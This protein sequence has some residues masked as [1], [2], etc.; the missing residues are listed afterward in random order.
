MSTATVSERHRNMA[1]AK[2]PH[3]LAFIGFGVVSQG[4]VQI[5]QAK[6]EHLASLGTS[7]QV[8]AISDLQKGAIYHPEGLALDQIMQSIERDGT[9]LSYPES[10]GLIRGWD[11]LTTIAKS[12][13]DTV[14]EATYTNI[15]TG[16]PGLDHCRAAFTAGKNV[17]TT[18][19]GPVALAYDELMHLAAEQGVR[20]AFEGTVM[21]GTPTLRLPATTLA[22]NT[23]RGIQGILNGT[24]N[25]IL[26]RMEEGLGYA[27]AL[28]EAQHLGYAEADPTNDVEGFD[29]LYKLL[30][31]GHVLFDQTIDPASITRVGISHLTPD[32]IQTAKE[33]G[34]RWKLVATIEQHDGGLRAAVSPQML[35][36]TDPLAGVSGAT[37]AM[38]YDCDLSGPVTVVGAGAGRIET[39]FALLIDCLNVVRGQV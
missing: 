35:S 18:N 10:E 12:N 1:S 22:G 16:Q 8:V 9:L 17:V 23:I 27:E 25:Y 32:D 26:T 39:G 2:N 29:A 21:S 20:F 31:L 36:L 13:A 5:L 38:T 3:R 15:R 28:A 6:E 4:F 34:K 19:K 37:N 30:I 24:T 14:I 33:E 11:S 7:F